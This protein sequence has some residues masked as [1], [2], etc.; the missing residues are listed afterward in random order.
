LAIALALLAALFLPKVQGAREAAR[1]SQCKN[2]LKEIGL[3]LHAYHAAYECFPPAFVAEN[4][5]RP[6]HSWR[7]LILPY[8]DEE[9]RK[10]HAQYN[11]SEPW[12][13]PQ[14]KKLLDRRPAVFACPTRAHGACRQCTA[15]AAVFGPQCVFRGT[16]PVSK[17]EIT[18]DMNETLLIADV[19][20]ADIPWTKPQDIDITQHPK[21]GDRLG[22]SSDHV[23]GFQAVFADGGVR[24]LNSSIGQATLKALSTRN[25]QDKPGDF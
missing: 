9:C 19:T 21:P 20:E 24:F 14:N 22:L 12:D 23:G 18:D 15:Y 8:L 5:G 10:L 17:A 25:G 6:M 1:R 11:F 7:V 3:A 16:D 13:G 2:N 4:A